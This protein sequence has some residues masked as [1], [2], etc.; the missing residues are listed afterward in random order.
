MAVE[1]ELSDNS[2][3][4]LMNSGGGGTG[5]GGGGGGGGSG[6]NN[7]FV[8]VVRQGVQHAFDSY[9]NKDHNN[10]NQE[11]TTNHLNT[12]KPHHQHQVSSLEGLSFS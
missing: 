7:F 5:G 6:T 3:T 10:N 11:N 4:P 8:N 9:M 1:E 12:N 2:Q